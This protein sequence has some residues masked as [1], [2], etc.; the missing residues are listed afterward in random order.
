[1]RF[2]KAMMLLSTLL[3]FTGTTFAAQ[4]EQASSSNSHRQHYQ[5][6]QATEK[7]NVNKADLK[8]LE[9]LKYVGKKTAAA[10]VEYRSKNGKFKSIED[11]SKVKGVHARVIKANKERIVF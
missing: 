1:M 7:V 11:L 10:I 8:T 3:L 5:K 9:T 2:I 6:Q 4:S